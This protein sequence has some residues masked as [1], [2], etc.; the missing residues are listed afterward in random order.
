MK[1]LVTLLAFVAFS[2]NGIAQSLDEGIKFLYY[3]KNKSAKEVFQKLVDKNSKDANAI[4][5]LGQAMLAEDNIKDAKALYQKALTEGNNNPWI[6]VGMG[7]VEILEN[8][9]LNSAKQKFEQAI[10]ATKN[11]K[12]NE[13]PSILNAI[14]RANADGSSKQGDPLYG[15]EKLKRSIELDS[16]NP[17]AFINLGIN[18]LKLG[19]EHGG[20]AVEAFRNAA[21][22]NPQYAAAYYRMGRVYQSQKNKESMDEQFAKAIS[23]DPAFPPVYIS[24]FLYYQDRDVN[25]AKEYLDKFVQ[26]AD[27][28]CY[29]DYFVADYL[30]RAGKYQES[31][32]K[33]QEME[34]GACANFPRINVLYAYDY[35]R[36]GDSLKAKSYIEKFFA[37]N[38]ASIEPTDYVFAGQLLS[39]FPGDTSAVSY[40]EKAIE[41]DTVKENQIDYLNTLA[42]LY[43]KDSAFLNQYNTLLRIIELK[44]TG[45]SESD[46]YKLSS[47]AL[48]S[49]EC[50]IAD[51]ISKAYVAAYPDKPQGYSFNVLAAKM[52][53]ADTSQGLA[54]EPILKYN[55]Y[56]MKDTAANKKRIFI[57]D[58]YLLLYYNDHAKDV[59][60]AIETLDHMLMLYPEPGEEN[61]F[62]KSTK[63]ALIKARK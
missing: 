4:Y 20:E 52:C 19:T 31:L 61:S 6:W 55:E 21:M 46:Y 34:N 37:S 56:M 5:W 13:D 27:K 63:D 7:H 9:D 39:K 16:K 60:K 18:Y 3:E 53:D 59:D 10:T 1:T 57:N 32:A 38:P 47:A 33:T 15:I 50:T 54:V 45:T 58:Y 14:G 12:G 35:D 40:L 42:E 30:F 2:F 43:E 51:S 17:D 48:D 26:Y 11:R 41:A 44:G 28:D 23:A 22:L 36:L 25:V 29:T 8:G 62:A 24:Y 49:K